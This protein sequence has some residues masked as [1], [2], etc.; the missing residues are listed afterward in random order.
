LSIVPTRPKPLV[1]SW[2]LTLAGVS[3]LLALLLLPAVSALAQVSFFDP[4]NFVVLGE[5]LAAGMADFG[6]RSVYQEKSFPA[7]M[8]QQM[9]VAFPQPLMQAAGIGSVPGFPSLPVRLPGPDQGAVRKDFPPQLFVFNLSVPGFRVRDALTRRPAPPLVQRND[10]LQSV[11]NLI[12]GYPSLILKDKPL[13][14]QVEYA[15]RMRPSLVLVELGYYDVLEAAA[16][17]DPA[18]LTSVEEFRASYS[19]I[20]KAVRETDATLIVLT[21]PD[22][23]DT[24]YF[25]PLASA[26]QNVGASAADLQALYNLQAG[27]LLTPNGLTAIALQFDANEIGELP[28][29]SVIASAV[30]SQIRSRVTALN[31][32]IQSLGEENG[33]VVY[34]LHGL[35]ARVRDVGLVV[36]DTR[37]LT[38]DYLGGFY[39]LNGYYPGATGHALIANEL[40]SLLNR[41]FDT[42][43]PLIDLAQVSEDDP[44]VRFIPLKK[45][46]SGELQ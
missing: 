32:V 18:R 15:Q 9:D 4:T 35:F 6:L 5:G 11:T 25:T 8:A 38:R 26:S 28:P 14:T 42:T 7:Q 3:A 41:T 40:L 13:W 24:A 12:L 31:Q 1:P 27:D 45:P 22:P 37:T 19:D 34:D 2:K 43:F 46:A 33:A 17:G 39:S 10:E 21:I 30:A 16:T 36:S 44:A 23:L 29:G 20:L